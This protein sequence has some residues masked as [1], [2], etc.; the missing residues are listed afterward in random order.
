MTLQIA[1]I[2]EIGSASFFTR[3]S[4]RI[5]NGADRQDEPTLAVCLDADRLDLGRVGIVPDPARLSTARARDIARRRDPRAG[6]AEESAERL[7][8]VEAVG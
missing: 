7:Y 3:I 1:D 2:V 5:H 8:G 4:C 6:L